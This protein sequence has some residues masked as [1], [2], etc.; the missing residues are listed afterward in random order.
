MRIKSCPK[1]EAVLKGLFTAKNAKNA[2]CAQRICCSIS[3]I[4]AR[5]EN[6]LLALERKHKCA[7]CGLIF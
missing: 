4:C 5:C 7:P 6:T 3:N 2:Q 1:L